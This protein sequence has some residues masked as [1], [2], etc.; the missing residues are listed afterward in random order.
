MALAIALAELAGEAVRNAKLL[1]R[2]RSLSESDSLTGLA[3]HR[4]L[5]E[6]LAHEQARAER[7]GSHFSLVMLD[8]D[9]FK[10]LND[11]HGH[12]WPATPS[13]AG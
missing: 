3:N 10:L 1:R 4:K 9:E 6:V 11:T 5:H 7:Y 12:P 13:C 2:L 8:I